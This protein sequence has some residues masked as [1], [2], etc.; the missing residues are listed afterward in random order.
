MTAPYQFVNNIISGRSFRWAVTGCAGFIGSHLIEAL[1]SADQEVLGIDSFVTG[2]ERNLNIVKSL[3][4]AD[5]FSRFTFTKCDI[6]ETESLLQ[7]FRGVDFVLH[8]A[9]LGSVPRSLKEP[10][11]YHDNNVTGTASVFE[12]CRLAGVKKVVFASSSSVYG[13]NVELPKVEER[14]GKALS[15]YALSKQMNEIDADLYARVYGLNSVGLR[16]F[17]V[18]GPRQDPNG[19]YAAVIPRWISTLSRGESCE[20]YGDGSTSR[21]FSPVPNIVQANLLSALSGEPGFKV[22]NVGLG[23][24]TS[25]ITLY[26]LIRKNVSSSSKVSKDVSRLDPKFL[27]ERKGDIKHSCARITEITKLGYQEVVSLVQGIAWTV[28]AELSE[29]TVS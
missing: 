29:I 7:S 9:A 4:G 23:N 13:D 16:Y 18:F 2:K 17:N 8:Q 6:R 12:A 19:A 28:D 21:D 22:F 24:S 10:V 3:V 26:D 20:I 1:L 5:K 11:L 25:L 14:I 15:P 27:P